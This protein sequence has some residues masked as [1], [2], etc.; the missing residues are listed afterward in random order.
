MRTRNKT[1][2]EA[3]AED[4]TYRRLGGSHKSPPIPPTWSG[5]RLRVFFIVFV[6]ISDIFLIFAP[7]FKTKKRMGH[8]EDIAKTESKI[9]VIR[10]TQVI[11]DRDVAELYGVETKAINQA[12]KRNIEKFPPE[13][14][15]Q[16]SKEEK[17]E[18]VTKCDHLGNLRYS[19]TLP[20]AFTEQGLYM[21]ATILKSPIATETT[22]AIIDT[23]TKL[24]KLART[25]AKLNDEAEQ[26]I[27]PDEA[28]QGKLQ[29]MMNEVFADKLPLKM[30]KFAFSIN[31]GIAKLS[32]ETTRERKD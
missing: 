2:A 17:Q 30:R 7:K 8:Q 28:E 24:R 10:D 15:F 23:F 29:G 20:N 4:G 22:F 16:L 5:R 18:V 6:G 1:W 26:G 25:M 21:L 11:L 9:I 13:Y 27:V 31:L 14:M 32:F 3:R 12:V 19:R